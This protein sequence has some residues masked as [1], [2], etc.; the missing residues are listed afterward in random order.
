MT[1]HA[2]S[3]SNFCLNQETLIEVGKFTILWN[4]FEDD[5]CCNNCNDNVILGMKDFIKT[6]NKR[7]FKELAQE[8]KNKAGSIS[9][10]VKEY[11]KIHMYA[12]WAGSK[13]TADNRRVHIPIVVDFISSE[14]EK[15][16]IGALLAI[17]R[18]RNNLLHG[19]KC[20]S[21]LDNQIELFKAMNAILEEAIVYK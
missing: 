3:I 9:M 13:I 2:I 17:Y 7:F 4:I 1:N 21:A 18:V 8:L 6:L 20:C 16:P 15:E 14:G 10:N 5:K 12:E 19:I 11:V